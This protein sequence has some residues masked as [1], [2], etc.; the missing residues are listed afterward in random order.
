MT[1]VGMVEVAAVAA[2]KEEEEQEQEEEQEEVVGLFTHPS[3]AISYNKHDITATG[4]I[5]V[6]CTTWP[7]IS[8]YSVMTV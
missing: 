7:L 2:M 1:V 5:Y 8:D 3:I 4:T 6:L